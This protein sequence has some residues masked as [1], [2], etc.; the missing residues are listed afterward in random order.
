MWNAALRRVVRGEED[1]EREKRAAAQLRLRREAQQEAAAVKAAAPA[2]ASSE[3]LV[4]VDASEPQ[5]QQQGEQIQSQEED[6]NDDDADDDDDDHVQRH[7]LSR[8]KSSW[9]CVED[10]QQ[11]FC[12]ALSRHRRVFAV[13]E[14]DGRLSVWDNVAIRVITRE[15]DP[16]LVVVPEDAVGDETRAVAGDSGAAG[17]EEG[18]GDRNATESSGEATPEDGGDESATNDDGSVEADD[19]EEEDEEEEEE[20]EADGNTEEEDDDGDDDMD[21]DDEQED[22]ERED[23]EKKS[24]EVVQTGDGNASGATESKNPSPKASSA[25]A[26]DGGRAGAGLSLE[27]LRI[28]KTSLKVVTSCAWSCD[29]RWLFAG[30]EEKGNRRGRL[31]VWDV[32]AAS[33]FAT[34]RSVGTHCTVARLL[35]SRC[36]CSSRRQN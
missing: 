15:L 1:R 24:A 5:Q 18:D 9:S 33:I 25:A 27:E 14:R 19:D 12:L 21:D 31:C 2:A 8:A 29:T 13:G 10:S 32:D 22:E 23:E 4:G 6:T 26:G 3:P 35:I 17:A 11:A 7:L 34:F 30:C 20:E 28:V 16:T 36:M